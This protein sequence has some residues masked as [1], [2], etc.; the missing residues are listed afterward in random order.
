MTK[1]V[2]GFIRQLKQA[3]LDLVWPDYLQSVI[4]L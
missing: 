1:V 3:V 4:N 2:I